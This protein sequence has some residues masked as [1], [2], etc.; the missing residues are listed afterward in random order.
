MPLGASRLSFL[1]FQAE[2]QATVRTARTISTVGSAQVDTAQYN[3]GLASASFSTGEDSLKITGGIDQSSWSTTWT[4]ECWFRAASLQDNNYIVH[5]RGIVWLGGPSRS[6][7]ANEVILALSSAP[8]TS[9][10]Y[11][12]TFS[13][14]SGGWQTNQWYHLAV[15]HD[16][17]TTEV[18]VDGTSLGT[19]STKSYLFTNTLDFEIG[20]HL[21]SSG[22]DF[23]GHIDEI[24]ISDSVR[25]TS[26]FTPSTVPFANDANTQLLI[27]ADGT[28]ESTVFVDDIGV[29]RGA[30]GVSAQGN[31]QIDTA[32]SQFGG[33]SLYLNGNTNYLTTPVIELAGD[34]T[35]ECWFRV[36]NVSG[37]KTIVGGNDTSPF[38]AL[39]ITNN[40]VY[41]N[42]PFIQFNNDIVANTWYHVAVTRSGSSVRLFADGVQQGTTATN[43][44][45][46][47]IDEPL[48]GNTEIRIGRDAFSS[49]FAGYIDEFR[50]S[51]TARYTSGFTVPTTAFTND[52]DTLILLHMDGADGSSDFVDDN[53]AY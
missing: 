20:K 19:A 26:S 3:F 28:D 39:S 52:A 51:D 24:R 27:H 30:V 40:D 1:A 48:A 22:N 6:T 13:P 35:I 9:V 49:G 42:S 11:Y 4:F 32:Q 53:G 12:A 23:N 15:T 17:G 47:F 18:F 44:D 36:D 38:D 14:V 31:A 34:Y 45:T 10:S 41:W 7:Q 37:G 33:A 2:A 16:T 21:S 29:D 46:I 50:I 8:N 25:Y 43:T 5:N